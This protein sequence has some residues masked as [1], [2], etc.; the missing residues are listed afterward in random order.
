MGAA[1]PDQLDPDPNNTGPRPDRTQT[2]LDLD[3]NQT[4]RTTTPVP[5]RAKRTYFQSFQQL[6]AHATYGQIHC[7][8][9]LGDAL[10]CKPSI[11]RGK[12]AIH[13]GSQEFCVHLSSEMPTPRSPALSSL[14]PP[15]GFRVA[16]V[17][18]SSNRYV[19][20]RRFFERYL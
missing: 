4:S 9:A 10:P 8:R 5:A 7:G 14:P 20:E 18:N 12:Y 2:G 13:D 1:R 3:L 15:S 11:S 19:R 6:P 16:H 17:D